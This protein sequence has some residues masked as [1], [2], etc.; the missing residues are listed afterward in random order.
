[1]Y[2]DFFGLAERPFDLTPNPRFLVL[3][4]AHREAIS[5]LEYGMLSRKGITLMLGEAGAG[6]T[7]VIRT[8]V[9]RQP[10][11][12]HCV[13]LHN[14]ALTRAEFVETLATRFALSH[15]AR[16]SKAAL[17]AELET[18]LRERLARGESSALI[19]DEA[20]SLPLELLEEIRL[21][22]NIET[23]E[24]KLLS[25]VLAGQPE[26]PGYFASM[27]RINKDGPAI[28]GGFQVP[29]RQPDDTV[30]AAVTRG[31]LVVDTRPAAAYALG[32][33]AGTVNIPL[34]SSFVSWAGWLIPPTADLYVI[35]SDE[36]PAALALLV[37]ALALIGIDS[38]R[39]Y[40]G[41]M[42]IV[43]AKVRGESL[44]T[45]DQVMPAELS[46]RPPS[47]GAVVID[48]RSATEW[49]AGHI[50][51]ALHIPLGYL[52]DRLDSLPRSQTLITQ[53]QSG[54]RSAI[55]ASLLKQHGFER[56][57]NLAGG[58]EQWRDAGFPVEK[59]ADAAHVVSA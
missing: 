17:L 52:I 37:R 24:T 27:K 14:P 19:V 13:H 50:P 38:V 57:L 6:K 43:R 59:G 32:H 7:L 1:M 4:A 15:E 58:F 5:N 46:Q 41:E 56:V 54:A 8:A 51:G 30:A 40:F 47:S 31:A 48:V 25:I 28:L 18:A 10:S 39:G 21:L 33:I 29:P 12:T 26:P 3:T 23:S 42:A 36:T 9:D 16:A 2:E 55:A 20:Q 44:K 35:V 34:N 22:G 45:I 53:C 11:T 49:A